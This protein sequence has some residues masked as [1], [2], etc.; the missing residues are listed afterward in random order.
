MPNK[1][2]ISL[3]HVQIDKSNALV[4]TFIAIAAACLVF[5]L[6]SVS[7]LWD[8]ANY[9]K[10][11]IKAKENTVSQVNAN[12]Q[13]IESLKNSYQ[14]FIGEPTN[15]IGGVATGTGD[16]D[17]DNAKITLDAM[18]SVYDFP[19]TISGFSKVL[20]GRS[21]TDLSITGTD[22]EASKAASTDV[23]VTPVP[24]QVSAIGSI[25]ATQELLKILDLSIRPVK[26][27]TVSFTGESTGQLTVSVDL[28]TYYQPKKEFEV[29]TEV[30]K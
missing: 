27:K 5:S 17:G 15:V 30:V 1:S 18:P 6:V 26:A 14:V 28:E 12:I 20:N 8:Q 29:K 7:A 9:N 2:K 3:R 16:R 22:E 4:V 11:V 25:E 23:S 19:G 10:R 21:F 13:S 24:L